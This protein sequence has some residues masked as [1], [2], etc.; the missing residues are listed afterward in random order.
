MEKKSNYL[1]KSQYSSSEDIGIPYTVCLF[2]MLTLLA[3]GPLGGV[4]QVYGG[5]L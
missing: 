1:H 2:Y 5:A 3:W 4:D